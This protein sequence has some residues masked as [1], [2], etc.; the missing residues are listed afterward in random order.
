MRTGDVCGQSATDVNLPVGEFAIV[1]ASDPAYPTLRN[2]PLKL[3]L[4]APKN[5]SGQVR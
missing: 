3:E 2:V 4:S 1:L 5:P